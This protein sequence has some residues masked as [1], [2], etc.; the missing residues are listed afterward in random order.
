MNAG[1]EVSCRK[2]NL[3]PMF[4]QLPQVR[5]AA[6][7]AKPLI[8]HPC[9]HKSRY[10][11]IQSTVT[12]ESTFPERLFPECRLKELFIH[13]TNLYIALQRQVTG[14]DPMCHGRTVTIVKIP[15]RFCTRWHK[16]V[17]LS[18]SDFV[19]QETFDNI[20]RHFLVV[21]TEGEVIMESGG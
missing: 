8:K 3:G 13:S 6:Q 17:A 15:K 10:T 2:P 16:T 7:P 20:R 5:Y 9:T 21:R 11:H 4:Q 19:P 12:Y 1:S 14:Q 18:Y